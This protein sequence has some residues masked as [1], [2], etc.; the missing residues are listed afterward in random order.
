MFLV[1]INMGIYIDTDIATKTTFIVICHGNLTSLNISC[2]L[3][4]VSV[5]FYQLN[6]FFYGVVNF[7]VFLCFRKLLAIE[8]LEYLYMEEVKIVKLE[9]ETKYFKLGIPD[10]M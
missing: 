2:H 5:F 8:F 10:I 7:P 6:S 1:A 9:F 4:I 3:L